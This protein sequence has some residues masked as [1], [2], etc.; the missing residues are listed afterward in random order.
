MDSVTTPA[1]LTRSADIAHMPTK[2]LDEFYN[3]AIGE[4]SYARLVEQLQSRNMNPVEVLAESKVHWDGFKSMMEGRNASDIQPEEYFEMLIGAKDATQLTM[5]DFGKKIVLM[6]IMNASN[7]AVL[8]D[9]A[10]GAREIVDIADVLDTDGPMKQIVDR[11]RYGIEQVKTARYL[12]GQAG[13]EMQNLK[14]QFV[15]LSNSA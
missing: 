4:E 11:L 2:E 3:E 12:W 9:Y 7:T 1:Q 8:R 10:I 13:R 6:D 15:V 14:E 5:V